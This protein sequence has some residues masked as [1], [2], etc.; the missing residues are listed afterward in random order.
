MIDAETLEAGSIV[1]TYIAPGVERE[2][3][4]CF[5]FTWDDDVEPRFVVVWHNDHGQPFFGVRDRYQMSLPASQT[6]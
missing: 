3:Q 1:K 6:N 2:V 4:V 5:G